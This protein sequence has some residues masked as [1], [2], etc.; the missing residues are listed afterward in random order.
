[1]REL[2]G[3]FLETEGKDGD[4][5]QIAQLLDGYDRNSI[6]AAPWPEYSYKPAVDFVIAYGKDCV[7]LK[8]YVSEKFVR[9]T[10]N[11]PNEPVYED[12]CV[13]FFVAFGDEDSYYNFEFNCAGTCMLGFGK[14]KTDRELLPKDVVMMIRH[15]SLLKPVSHPG[16]SNISWE[17]T[18]VIP[19]AVFYHHSIASLDD[20]QCRVNFYK[21][22]N[23]LPYPHYLAWNDI[24][25]P[26]PEFHLPG[27][28]GKMEFQK[29]VSTVKDQAVGF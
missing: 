13:E 18:L 24:I 6:T 26:Y 3:P 14:D 22:G 10:Y 15:Q 7:F 29:I 2:I 28:F 5:N 17:L 11:K 4:I 20:Q 9:A 27:F 23:E 1:M 21:C 16:D 8:Y 12:S 25:Y 19:F